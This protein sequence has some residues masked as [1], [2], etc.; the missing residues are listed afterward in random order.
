MFLFPV[1]GRLHRRTFRW[2]LIQIGRLGA[3]SFESRARRRRPRSTI[4]WA[5]RLVG[6]SKQKGQA[7]KAWWGEGA[8]ARVRDASRQT[9]CET[10][11]GAR[12]SLALGRVFCKPGVAVS[13]PGDAAI[14]LCPLCRLRSLRM[15]RAIASDG[16]GRSASRLDRL[17]TQLTSR[18][19]V[20]CIHRHI[21]AAVLTPYPVSLPYIRPSSSSPYMPP[22]GAHW[23]LTL[24]GT[25]L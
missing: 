25:Y 19:A 4:A 20:L 14:D 17:Y 7:W 18:H 16:S 5:V 1:Q 12:R 8:S 13:G 11:A 23:V 2:L 10:A 9:L 24:T 15:A 21:T 3:S 6:I 22:A